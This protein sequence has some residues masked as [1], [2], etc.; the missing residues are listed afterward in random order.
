MRINQI[1]DFRNR[2]IIFFAAFGSVMILTGCQFN[3]DVGEFFNQIMDQISPKPTLVQT[4]QTPILEA[5]S[6]STTEPQVISSPE[7]SELMELVIWVPPQFDPQSGTPAGDLFDQRIRQ[8]ES[9]HKDVFID[10]RVKPASGPT[11]LLESL[12]ITNEAAQKAMPSITALSRSDLET[13]VS[14]QLIYAFEKYSSKIDEDDWY[15][16][17][18]NLTMVGGGSFGLPFAGDT[19]VLLHR[20][21]IIGSQPN[22]WLDVLRRGEPLSFSGA[23]PQAMFAMS[24]YQASGG[25]LENT[26]RLPQLNLELLTQVFQLIAD[27][28]Q[29]G[30]FPLWTTEFQKDS[31]A[32]TAYNE[33]RS[34]WVVTWSTRYLQDL[35]SDTALAVFPMIKETPVSIADGWVWCITDPNIEHHSLS[36]ELI[37]FLSAQDFLKSWAPVAGV[38]PVRPSS[39]AGWNN[40]ELINILGQVATYAKVRPRNEVVSILGPIFEEQVV[41]ILSGKTSAPI[42]AQTVIDKVGNP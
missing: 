29:T 1:S 40:Q 20:P 33:L 17:A 6:T 21:E 12:S 5:E 18:R 37:E 9:Q 22:T 38:L 23:D 26:Q 7:I 3:P 2:L 25:V 28:G 4:D 11:G 34:N 19:L 39:L 14:Q 41:L 8:F 30:T 35:S 42:A 15:Q 31:D 10:V 32:W 13:A 27:G 24:L 36:A 16:Y